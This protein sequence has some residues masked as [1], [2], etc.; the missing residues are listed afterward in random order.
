MTQKDP[1]TALTVANYLR[2]AE[3]GRLLIGHCN[4]CGDNHHYPRPYCPFCLSADTEWLETKGAG[5]IYSFTIWRR[6]DAVTVPAFVKLDEGPTLMTEIVDCDVDRLAI[7]QRVRLAP[8][9]AARTDPLF[10]PATPAN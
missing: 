7:G 9:G 4:S 6:R 8:P 1:D 5:V 2:A 3:A 10:M